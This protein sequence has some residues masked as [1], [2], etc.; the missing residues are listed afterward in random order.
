MAIVFVTNSCSTLQPSPKMNSY[1]WLVSTDPRYNDALKGWVI[2]VPSSHKHFQNLPTLLA[3]L[4]H[5]CIAAHRLGQYFSAPIRLL[6]LLCASLFD[7]FAGIGASLKKLSVELSLS[8]K[9]FTAK[10]LSFVP[11]ISLAISTTWKTTKMHSR[12]GKWIVSGYHQIPVSDRSWLLLFWKFV[13]FL[14][15]MHLVKAHYNDKDHIQA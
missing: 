12:H 9:S 10:S 14:R 6:H 5:N 8:L 3:S 1:E 7:S 2:Q 13:L 15:Q 4:N 11:V